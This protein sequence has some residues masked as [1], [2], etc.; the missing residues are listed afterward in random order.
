MGRALSKRGLRGRG[1][2]INGTTERVDEH[3]SS[4]EQYRT[5]RFAREGGGV[6]FCELCADQ[7]VG[8]EGI[9]PVVS[10]ASLTN[11]IELDFGLLS[12]IW[13]TMWLSLTGRTLDGR[14]ME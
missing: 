2:N 3:H 1:L 13:V 4:A 12:P 9:L 5:N 7:H 6:Q 14:R 10:E 11:R 8:N